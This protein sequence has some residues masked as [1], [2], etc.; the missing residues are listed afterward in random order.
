MQYGGTRLV[1]VTKGI[2]RWKTVDLM[3]AKLRFAR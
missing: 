2:M 3:D 1:T